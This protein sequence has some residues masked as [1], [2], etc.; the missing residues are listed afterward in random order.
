VGRRRLRRRPTA[1]ALDDDYGAGLRLQR[2]PTAESEWPTAGGLFERGGAAPRE[3]RVARA[4]AQTAGE[5]RLSQAS[6][7]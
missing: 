1:A 5:A 6:G 2:R 4:G 7:K 3:D